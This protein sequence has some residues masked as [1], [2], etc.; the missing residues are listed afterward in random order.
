MVFTFFSKKYSSIV[1]GF[2]L[3]AVIFG[4]TGC[5][6]TAEDQTLEPTGPPTAAVP[7]LDPSQKAQENVLF[8][9]HINRQTLAANPEAKGQDFINGL[10]NAGFNRNAME[11]TEDFTSINLKAN[12][13]Q[14]SVRMIDACLIGQNG[15]DSNGYNSII[16]PI[17]ATQTCLVGKT[18]PIDW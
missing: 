4:L 2:L 11:V 10:I 1:I 16:S 5:G 15:P 6:E 8:F 14:F 9:D 3:F 17:L 13:I 12:S 7:T 18:R